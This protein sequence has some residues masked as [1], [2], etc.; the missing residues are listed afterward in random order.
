MP[1]PQ[2]LKRDWQRD[3]VYLIQFPRAGCIPSLSMFCL[4]LET[5]LR[6]TKIPYTNISN[7]FTKFSYKKQ[8]P[9]IELNGRQIPDSNFCIDH[10]TQVFKIDM[11]ER[12]NAMEKAHARAFSYLLE[13]SIRWIIVH[14]R[15]KNNKFMAREEG[16]IKHFRGAKKAL[17]QYIFVEQ[18]RKKIWKVCYAQGIGRHSTD[19]VEQI[20]KKDL[21][22]LSVFLDDKKFFFGSTPTTLDATAFGHLAQIYYAPM[23]SN[24]LQKYMEKNTPNLVEFLKRMRECYW[25]DWDEA[26]KLLTLNTQNFASN[27]GNGEEPS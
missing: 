7:D 11:D 9:F 3:H 27:R 8:I 24:C 5:W 25:N 17:F 1:T 23:I 12:L 6:I 15:G 14:N 21:T 16:F 2:L 13:E 10:L 4:K 22:A 20:A 18:F 26:C 19:E